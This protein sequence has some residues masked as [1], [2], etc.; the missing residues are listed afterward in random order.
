MPLPA[1]TAILLAG[2]AAGSLRALAQPSLETILD[3]G[4]ASNRL[5]LVVLSEG[6][7]A[8]Q[9]PRFLVDATNVVNT[10]LSHS[11]YLEYSNYANAFALSV[12]SNESG[13]DHPL[14]GTYRDTYFNSSF[15]S[16]SDYL[17][18]IPAGSTGQGKVDALLQT[19]MPQCHLAILLV[20]DPTLGGSDGFNQTAIASTGAL[21]HE[22]G[23]GQPGILTHETG[24]V[25]AGLGDEYTTP[26]PGF[27]DIEEPN[28]TRETNRS[29]I[30]WG[31]WIA[32]NT[33]VPTP[34]SYGDGVVGLFE[35]AHYHATGWYR[36][37]L[38][39]A[40]NSPGVPF[41]PVCGEAI[42]LAIYGKL[43]PVDGFSPAGTN[44]SVTNTEILAFNLSLL[45]PATHDLSVQWFTNSVPVPDATNPVFALPPQSLPNGTNWVS[46]V[47][48]DSTLLV[49]TDPTNLLSQTITWALDLS[50]PRLR[51][52]SPL[53]LSG[54]QFAFRVSGIAPH[55]F[56]IQSA[57][58]LSDWLPLTTNSLAGGEFWH[59]NSEPGSA[60]RK[61]YRA[62]VAP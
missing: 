12:A 16:A 38:N 14:Y 35:G 34:E 2:L 39:C 56:I 6:Y 13:S 18:N 5:N 55:G 43:K 21:A 62:V 58:N 17:I 31:A 25:L 33:P 20:D 22:A 45:Q 27:P 36:P 29:L 15:D 52:D 41:C 3:N 30:K 24:H 23:I 11:P 40:M 49:R 10:L 1:A 32:T 26:Y 50:L 46:A 28:T 19:F 9:L 53:W 60:P 48:T 44:L 8:S 42:V 61:F 37:Q 51:L 4:P 47:V 7:T 59:T 57:T 54:S